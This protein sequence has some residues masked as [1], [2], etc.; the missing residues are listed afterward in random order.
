MPNRGA[1]AP[2]L[3]SLPSMANKGMFTENKRESQPAHPFSLDG[4]G[5]RMRAPAPLG[6]VCQPQSARL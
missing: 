6:A 1:G 5:Y 3:D 2:A 4:E